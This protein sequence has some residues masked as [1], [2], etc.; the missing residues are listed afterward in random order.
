M[1]VHTFVGSEISK[2]LISSRKC[3]YVFLFMHFRVYYKNLISGAIPVGLY[4]VKVNNRNTRTRCKICSK[5]TMKTTERRHWRRSGVFIINLVYFTPCSIVSTVNFEHVIAGWINSKE[6]EIRFCL[7]SNSAKW[8]V[9]NLW[10]W[11]S[12]SVV[13][14]WIRMW[15]NFVGHFIKQLIIIFPLI[16]C[17]FYFS[18]IS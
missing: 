1:F 9:R 3:L 8:H 11:E 14:R 18:I 7:G 17:Y 10:R 16:L 13:P 12:L 2:E 15:S 4:L 5:L 6:S